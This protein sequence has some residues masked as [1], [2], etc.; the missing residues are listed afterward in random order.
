MV[1]VP[2]TILQPFLDAADAAASSR[3]EVD[4]D[5]AREL[6]A[7]AA[8]MLHNSLALDHLDEH[9]HALAVALLAADLTAPD[10]TEA[11][12]AR[13]TTIAEDAALHDPEGVHGAYLVVMQ[14]FG[15]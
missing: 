13:A 9:D 11:V 5:I 3:P 10:P 15:L 8:A 6:M 14:V 12:R 2:P 4:G 1:T 7:E